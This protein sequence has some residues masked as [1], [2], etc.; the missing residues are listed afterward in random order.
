MELLYRVADKPQRCSRCSAETVVQESGVRRPPGK[1]EEEE[2][3]SSLLQNVQ[4]VFGA[5]PPS[6]PMETVVFPGRKVARA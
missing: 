5:Q 3:K 2:E 1:E 4:T 6:F